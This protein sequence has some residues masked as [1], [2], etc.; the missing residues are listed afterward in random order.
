L[1]EVWRF[2]FESPLYKQVFRD[3]NTVLKTLVIMVRCVHSYTRLLPAY[4]LFCDCTKKKT[5]SSGMDFAVASRF[6]NK[7]FFGSAFTEQN[8]CKIITGTGT[9][10]ASVKY[11]ND[12][13]YLFHKES[14][15]LQSCYT[16]RSPVVLKKS[17]SEP[18]GLKSLSTKFLNDAGPQ[19]NTNKIQERN[20]N[21]CNNTS[22]RKPEAAINLNDD[23]EEPF[24]MGTPPSSRFLLPTIHSEQRI[25]ISPFRDGSILRESISNIRVLSSRHNTETKSFAFVA[26]QPTIT[27]NILRRST[28][29]KDEPL[30]NISSAGAY[31]WRTVIPNSLRERGYSESDTF[32]TVRSKSN[33]DLLLRVKTTHDGGQDEDLCAY[34]LDTFDSM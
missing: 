27:Q 15:V 13:K 18:V 24:N 34:I 33:V 23:E 8:F 31:S 6:S 12:I 20:S 22:P 30:Q 2:H 1:L 4:K 9:L 29:I 25:G 5:A 21:V 19:I 16:P 14:I 26:T 7:N 11:R 32:P 10:C 28:M 3:L 17:H